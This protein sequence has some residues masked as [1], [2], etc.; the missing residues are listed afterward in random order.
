M[1]QTTDK[2]TKKEVAAM[3][4]EA[5]QPFCYED[6]DW[7]QGLQKPFRQHDCI[8]ASEGH[9]LIR[10]R[11][12]EA[13]AAIGQ[14]QKVGKPD[15]ESV[16]PAIDFEHQLN[17]RIVSRKDM[18]AL[19]ERMKQYEA[20]KKQLTVADVGGIRLVID[21]LSRM[22]RAMAFCGAE[23]ARL[24]WHE[25]DKV[26]VELTNERD[27]EAVTILQMGCD[28]KD[29]RVF[30]L[31]TTEATDDADTRICWQRGM[32]AWREAKE[33]LAREEEA[34][35]MAR[36]EVYMVEVVKRAYVPVYAKNADEARYLCEKHCGEPEKEWDAEWELGDTVPEAEDAEDVSEDYKTCITSEGEVPFDRIFEME[37][38]GEQ[39]HQQQESE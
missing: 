16:I 20:E 23:Q 1:K 27:Q 3:L 26:V 37:Q 5:L 36:R 8:C 15:V 24:V 10:I 19:I 34:E 25:D 32:E 33:K 22:E 12:K 13:G 29:C 9:V 4:S 28:P 11:A 39:W 2:P 21:G 18:A 35:R 38:I 7:A 17:A 31:L 6:A 30:T 14:F